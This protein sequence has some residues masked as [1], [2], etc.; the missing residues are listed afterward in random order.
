MSI[1]RHMGLTFFSLRLSAKGKHL[2]FTNL[3]EANPR[4]EGSQSFPKAQ[5]T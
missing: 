3:F 5:S 1:L 2:A 4:L